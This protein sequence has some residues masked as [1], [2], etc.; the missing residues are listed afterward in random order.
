[1]GLKA[2]FCWSA[3]LT[4]KKRNMPETAQTTEVSKSAVAAGLSSEF[5]T[6][7]HD[8]EGRR[9]LGEFWYRAAEI[10]PGALVWTTIV[11]SFALSFV[12]PLVVICF[13]IVFDVFWMY[14][15]MHFCFLVLVA[16]RRYRRDAAVDWE[17]RVQALPRFVEIRHLVFLPT[18]KESLDILRGTLEKLRDCRYP[19]VKDRFLVVLAGE[20]RDRENFE[21]HVEVL[22][23]EFDGEFLRLIV[24][25]HPKDLP[26]EVVGKGANTNW[27]ARKARE[28]VDQL[29]LAYED[30]IVSSFDCDTVVHPQYFSYLTYKYLT[31]P[32]PTRSSYQP[33]AFYNNNMWDATA[34]VRI[35]AFGT[36]F[37]LMGELVRP[38]RLSTFSSHSMSMR[39]LVDVGYWQ[40]DIVTE[41]SRIFLQCLLRY[42]GDY[43]VTPLYLPVSMDAVSGDGLWGSIVNLYKQ[44][45]RW[46]WGIEH[47]PYLVSRFYRNPRFPWRKK[48]FFLWNIIEGMYTWA[49]APILIFV[50][51]RL[52][53]L[54]AGEHVRESVFF[55]NAPHTL[56][57][58]MSLSMAGIL[59]TALMSLALLPPLPKA[60]RPTAWIVAFL[61]WALVPITFTTLGSFPAVDA[62]TRLMT[63]RYLGFNVTAKKR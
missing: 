55:Q 29:G 4:S 45:R 11:L 15:V 48:V 17:A 60:R 18:Y 24:T 1:M 43:S 35:A 54:V 3:V 33:M 37:W 20:E 63:G 39:A 14:R 25:V 53:L 36:T 26:G 10:L 27:A 19:G 50:L 56:E 57:T 59:F 62:Q 46:A 28:V 7:H 41:D 12:S 61:Q 51:G 8:L 32:N 22:K 38:E 5:A 49:T 30:V 6:S 58:L 13:I 9:R 47:F 21:R 40:K 52:P 31:H 23:K 2:C 42:D 34:P 44:Q 16:W